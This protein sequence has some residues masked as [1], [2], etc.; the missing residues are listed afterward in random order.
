VFYGIFCVY[1]YL[2]TFVLFYAKYTNQIKMLFSIQSD[3]DQTQYF[4]REHPCDD[5][6]L[7]SQYVNIILMELY[8]YCTWPKSLLFLPPASDPNAVVPDPVVPE[9]PEDNSLPEPHSSSP[10]DRPGAIP[11]GNPGEQK[12]LTPA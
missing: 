1:I 4:A 5:T 9:V 11:P 6:N 3:L 2:C 7:S 12:P 8:Y 10:P